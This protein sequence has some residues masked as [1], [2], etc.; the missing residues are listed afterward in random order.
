LEFLSWRKHIFLGAFPN[1]GEPM[2]K[3]V[4]VHIRVIYY[5]GDEAA[6][7]G[8]GKR[9]I[10]HVH[11]LRGDPRSNRTYVAFSKADSLKHK[12]TKKFAKYMQLS[13]FILRAIGNLCSLNK[14]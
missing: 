6:M 1:Y 3:A 4:Q 7:V 12:S 5:L 11:H 9:P 2:T 13:A 14:A 10:S 8:G